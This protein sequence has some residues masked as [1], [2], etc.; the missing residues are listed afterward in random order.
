ME[1][2]IYAKIWC[3][4]HGNELVRR[5][6]GTLNFSYIFFGKL[7]LVLHRWNRRLAKT[8]CW[9][10]N[11]DPIM[12]LFHECFVDILPHSLFDLVASDIL[13]TILLLLLFSFFFLLFCLK[14]FVGSADLRKAMKSLWNR[15]QIMLESS[16][17]TWHSR[18]YLSSS[19]ASSSTIILNC[20]RKFA[21]LVKT[22]LRN[23]LNLSAISRS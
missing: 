21:N 23:T 7:T 15:C 5:L 16:H 12:M 8:I 14:C 20:L 1:R 18:N 2:N 9:M 11:A 13:L 6:S 10:F 19:V 22:F 3:E 4:V 17:S